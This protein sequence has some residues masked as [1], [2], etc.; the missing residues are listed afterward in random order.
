MLLRV[1]MFLTAVAFLMPCSAAAG[2]C[3]VESVQGT[4]E[5]IADEIVAQLSPESLRLMVDGNEL[6]QIWI[7][8]AWTAAESKPESTTDVPIVYSLTPGSLVGA[9]R[10]SRLCLNL[11][12]EEIPPGI[13]TLRYVV[14]PEFQEHEGSHDVRDFLLLLA[15]DNDQSKATIEDGDDLNARSAD[16]VQAEH[17]SFLPLMEPIETDRE[18]SVRPD[19]QDP[20]GWVLLLHGTDDSGKKVPM[21]IIIPRDAESF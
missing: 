17:P 16:A 14:Q 8:K 15:A 7:A 21:E 12:D 18:P 1:L 11:R 5:E 3:Q 13:Y 9:I 4:P 10:I 2:E 19:P 20:E 6:C